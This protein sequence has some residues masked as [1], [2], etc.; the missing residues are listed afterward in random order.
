MNALLEQD[1]SDVWDTLPDAPDLVLHTEVE[2]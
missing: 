1:W 2:R